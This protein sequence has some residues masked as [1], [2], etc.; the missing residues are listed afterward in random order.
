MYTRNNKSVISRRC[1]SIFF[2]KNSQIN[3]AKYILTI[4][5]VKKDIGIFFI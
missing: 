4:T 2:Y 3:T 5:I 1:D